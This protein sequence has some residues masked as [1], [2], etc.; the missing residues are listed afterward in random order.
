MEDYSHFR[1][2]SELRAGVLVWQILSPFLLVFGTFG[3]ALSIKVLTT[4]KFL[5][6]TSTVY[7]L[8]LAV[9]DLSLLYVG[10]LRQWI[11]YTFDKDIRHQSGLL[12][13][14]HWYAM[15][16]CSDIAVWI[17][18]AITVERLVATI[19][20]LKSRSVCTKT[21]AKVVTVSIIVTALLINV[22]ILYGFGRLELQMNNQTVIFPCI[23][24]TK[25]YEAFFEKTWTWIDLCKF[26]LLPF[27]ILTSGNICIVYRLLLSSKKFKNKV[28][29]S[30]NIEA[31]SGRLH[32]QRRSN[33]SILLVCLNFVFIFCTLPVCVYFI[34]LPN[35]IPKDIPRNIQLQ[36]PWWALVNML[37]YL[38]Y[39]CNFIMYCLAGSRFRNEVRKLFKC[40]KQTNALTQTSSFRA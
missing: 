15:Y 33:M 18:P 24:L 25:S 19:C 40:G 4:P 6:S 2:D 12:C 13:K 35:F 36:D 31:P 32:S 7:L 22:H 23:P 16:T 5:R 9:A 37:L 39:S 28:A 21:Y 3:N 8:A 27:A 20:P 1:S 14:L 34:G 10:L 29:P 38:N 26:S 17:L 30:G 11:K